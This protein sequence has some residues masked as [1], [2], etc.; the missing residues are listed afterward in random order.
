M[1]LPGA[2][3]AIW[4]I[5]AKTL[6]FCVCVWKAIKL[7]PSDFQINSK[8]ALATTTTTKTWTIQKDNL[9]CA[10]P[11]SYCSR[12]MWQNA[13]LKLERKQNGGF[14]KGWSWRMCPRSGFLYC[15]FVFCTL[16][17]VFGTLVPNGVFQTVFF[18]FLTLTCNKGKRFQR[19]K[20]SRKHSCFQAFWCLLRFVDPDHPLNTPL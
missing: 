7:L 13:R 10:R 6:R 14:V 9:C 16:V 15:C 19:D 2:G 20:D 4:E 17:P 8:H 1:Q 3:G 11:L 12:L 18:R 5:V